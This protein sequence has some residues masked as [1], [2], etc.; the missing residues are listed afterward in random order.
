MPPDNDKL[1]VIEIAILEGWITAGAPTARPEPEELGDG[2]HITEEER[3]F[4]AFQPVE[5]HEVPDVTH[6]GRVR[7]PIDA[8]L[9][10]RLEEQT[11][12]FAPDADKRTFIR[13]ATFD[14]LGM[15]PT[16]EEIAFFLADESPDAYE[17]L[18]D[19][20]LASPHYGERWGRHW[21]D[22]AGYA[23]SEG[24][25]DD[26]PERKH[27]Y[28]YRDYVIRSFNTDKPFDQFITE[29]LAGDEL[30]PRPY[31]NLGAED[32]ENLVATGFLRMAPDG[33]GAGGVDKAAASNAVVADTLKIVSSSLLGMTVACA[34]CHN[35]RY[36]PIPQSDYYRMRAIFE[37]AYDWKNW[38]A[39]SARLLSLYTD[40]DRARAAE[41]EAEAA[42]V[43][44]E[45]TAKQQQYIQETFEKQL[46]KVL[47]QRQD[48]VRSA[49]ETPAKER[50]PEQQQLLKEYPDVNV[51][52]GSLYLYDRSEERRV[53]KEG[54]SRWSPEH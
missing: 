20:L 53:G 1:T 52:A 24:Y 49:Y 17:R 26:D 15:P 36:D 13:R 32:V 34:Q 48:E 4:W 35:H 40:A 18:L 27:A 7:N 39:P 16:P 19:R 9:L 25:T 31:E 8:F 23:D 33:T 46:A 44:A 45:R 3:G 51:S 50:T 47:S 5:H 42:K 21:L 38:R 30:V 29:Q 28:K 14:L 11:L 2:F 43:D 6:A 22:V 10:S 37:P 41:I 54:R 12:R